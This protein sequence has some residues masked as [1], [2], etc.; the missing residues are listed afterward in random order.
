MTQAGRVLVVDDNERNLVIL[1]KTLRGYVLARARSGAEALVEA[2]RFRPDLVLLDVMMPE[3]DGYDTCRRLRAATDGP[4][5]KIIMLSARSEAVDRLKGYAAGAD[6]YV[7]K[8]FDPEELLAKV[9]V[10]LRLKSVE[11]IDHLRGGLLT[12]LHHETRTPITYLLSSVELLS[13]SVAVPAEARPFLD[14]VDDAARRLHEIVERVML[15]SVLRTG[16]AGLAPVEVDLAGEI[17]LAIDRLREAAADK[18]ITVTL[19]CAEPLRASLDVRCAE[20]VFAA[21]I[22]NAVRY[23]L[24]GASVHVCV[25]REGAD[26]LVTVR[27]TGPGIEP[28]N[29]VHV[30]NEFFV[31]DVNH[32]S[33]GLGLGLPLARQMMRAHHGDLSV[34]SGA[35]QGTCVTVRLPIAGAPVDAPVAPTP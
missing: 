30:C 5:P 25:T 24:G 32:H 23:S 21:L 19:E 7:A 11:E 35:G 29:L 4:A 17:Q 12:L 31:G 6:D 28:E 8:P 2:V 16:E 33:R 9:R 10:Y 1:E 34:E 3:M 26:A 14:M 27:D 22:D 15:L 20:V 18:H 13:E